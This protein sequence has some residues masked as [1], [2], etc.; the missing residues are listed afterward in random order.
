MKVSWMKESRAIGTLRNLVKLFTNTSRL[1]N[2]TNKWRPHDVIYA[3]YFEL[4]FADAVSGKFVIRIRANPRF[5]SRFIQRDPKNIS[6]LNAAD[7]Y[8]KSHPVTGDRGLSA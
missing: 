1:Y 8:G 3:I 6:C 5:G 4:D 2:L 7:S